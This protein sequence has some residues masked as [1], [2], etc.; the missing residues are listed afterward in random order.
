MFW[1]RCENSHRNNCGIA[2]LSR[3]QIRWHDELKGSE[4]GTFI[5]WVAR[6]SKVLQPRITFKYLFYRHW[7][8]IMK[9]I[10]SKWVQLLLLFH[11]YIYLFTYKDDHFY[12]RKN[13]PSILYIY[14]FI[15]LFIYLNIYFNM[16]VNSR[17]WLPK[18]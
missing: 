9:C 13:W 18:I 8:I 12:S 16:F 4:R 2:K 10:A 3:Y 17:V 14:L 5:G 11:S 1:L 6:Q 15:Y 7:S